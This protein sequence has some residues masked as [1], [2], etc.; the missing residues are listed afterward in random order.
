MGGHVMELFVRSKLPAPWTFLS[1]LSMRWH[2]WMQRPLYSKA[3]F[4]V[5]GKFVLVTPYLRPSLMGSGK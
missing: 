1:P 4:F 2:D 5:S 3:V